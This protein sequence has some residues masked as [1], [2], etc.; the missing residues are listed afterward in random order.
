V[1]A[2]TAWIEKCSASGGCIVTHGT[3]KPPVFHVAMS[4]PLGSPTFGVDDPNVQAWAWRC[5]LCRHAWDSH[6][7]WLA[8][9]GW[10]SR[11]PFAN[12]GNR[13]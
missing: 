2:S 4:R 3:L 5:P 1:A 12:S 8:V 6:P 7:V 9:T 10:S 13:P 11:S